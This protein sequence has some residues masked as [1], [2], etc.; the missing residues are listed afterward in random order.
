MIT[1]QYTKLRLHAKCLIWRL[2]QYFSGEW[3][4]QWFTCIIYDQ[5]FPG[6]MRK[7]NG[8]WITWKLMYTNCA[9]TTQPS[10]V[11]KS[12]IIWHVWGYGR[13][14]CTLIRGMLPYLIRRSLWNPTYRW[15]ALVRGESL[16]WKSNYALLMSTLWI[17]FTL[18]YLLHNPSI[19]L[20]LHKALS[21][22]SI[23]C[24]L[25]QH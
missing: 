21:V 10:R 5:D 11:S 23:Y 17:H 24:L 14:H 8:L 7:H 16:H 9:K 18:T 4:A 19:L 15:A 6:A 3:I 1:L 12:H 2:L 25:W 13:A 20:Q 22:M